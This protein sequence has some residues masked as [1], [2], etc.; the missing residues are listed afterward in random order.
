MRHES[1]EL[2]RQLAELGQQAQSRHN[3][4]YQTTSHQPLAAHSSLSLGL[5]SSFLRS[6]EHPILSRN[7]RH[8]CPLQYVFIA[9][10]LQDVDCSDGPE[11]PSLQNWISSHQL[12]SGSAIIDHL[13]SMS[14]V[15]RTIQS[16]VEA[17]KHGPSNL[18]KIISLS[19]L[20][21]D[22]RAVHGPGGLDSPQH[23]ASRF[24]CFVTVYIAMCMTGAAD[25]E[26]VTANPRAL[27]CL[28][29]GLKELTFM[30]EKEDFVSMVPYVL[31]LVH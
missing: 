23:A 3:T 2:K 22:C 27:A 1:S 5:P 15:R 12:S 24:R 10:D 17:T 31:V 9:F 19:Q 13:P 18:D 11:R 29:T 16:L 28:S 25:A 14:E 20:Q 26:D 6:N 30:T 4:V 21:E 8:T 7:L